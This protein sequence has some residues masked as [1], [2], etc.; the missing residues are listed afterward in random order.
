M[1][2]S[3]ALSVSAA[4]QL[5]KGALEQVTV[6]LVGEVCELNDKPGY[7]AV[8]FSVKDEYAVLP[9]MMWLNRYRTN[10]LRFKLGD[11]LELTGRFT[12]YAAKGRMS[13]DVFSFTLAGEGDLRARVD[14]LARKL[15]AEG[16]MDPA[17]K[18]RIPAFPATVG[19]VTSPRGD[20]VHDVFRTL[21]RRFP[22][23]DVKFAGV[24]V[25]GAEAPLRIMMGI[26]CLV[27]AD[28]EV[29]LVVRGGGSYE[30][31]MPYNDERL[32]RAIASCPV[33]VVTGIGHEPDTTISDMVADLRASTPT[34]AAEAVSPSPAELVGLLE[35]RRQALDG[36]IHRRLVRLSHDVELRCAKPIFSHPERLY[37]GEALHLDAALDA[38]GRIQANLVPRFA[39]KADLKA[40]R[41]A[42]LQ[43]SLVPRFAQNVALKASRLDDLSPLKVLSRGYAITRTAEGAIVKSV[44]Q[45]AAADEMRISVSDGDILASVRETVPRKIAQEG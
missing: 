42:D 31:L 13:F 12:L 1:E 14:R 40:S 34:A 39:Q 27:Q 35:G 32:A 4:L 9:C 33:P 37:E 21:R 26:E 3:Q 28:V 16:L 15:Q 11:V 24:P 29:I 30:D 20:A 19:V 17:R 38:L 25:E 7:K 8:Y 45:V 22:L 43:E 10:G 18:R 44:G 41:I 23:V 2:Q 6:R 5:A 36:T